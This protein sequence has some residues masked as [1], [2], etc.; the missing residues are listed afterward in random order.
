MA[1]IT[2]V[3]A[4][5][6]NFSQL[7]S[8]LTSSKL[9]ATLRGTG[10][11]TLFAPTNDAINA[12]PEKHLT[13][14]KNDPAKLSRIVKFHVVPEKLGAADLLNYH[15]IKMLEG[16]RL[17][18]TSHLDDV[19]YADTAASDAYGYVM[20]GTLTVAI[21]QTIKVNGAVITRPNLAA[22]NGF[23]HVIDRVL[24]PWLLDFT[25]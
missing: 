17:R 2:D 14:W 6:T 1:T 20:G 12:L 4:Q 23:V 8:A 3:L 22:D 24:I 7:V 25:K 15:F 5:D 9:D 10:P 11:Y 13:L 18:I 16:Q 21:V 19:G